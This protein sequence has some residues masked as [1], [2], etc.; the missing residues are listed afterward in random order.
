M[1]IGAALGSLPMPDAR[2]LMPGCPDAS[3]QLVLEIPGIPCSRPR[4]RH[5]AR[6]VGGRAV[7][8]TY[9]PRPKHGGNDP[10]SKAWAKA[11]AWYDAVQVAFWQNRPAD[12]PWEGPIYL[13]ADVFLPRPQKYLR[14][15]DP[16]GP[17]WAHT[18]SS[19]RDN[20]EKS[21]SDALKTA[22]AYGDDRQVV[23]G[24]I[25]KL[26][27]AKGAGPGVVVRMWRITEQPE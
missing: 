1:S 9:H 21:I 15:R 17:I 6:I 4:A 19:D 25:R 8:V 20:L 3:L 13:T 5:A 22:G 18:A 7:S 14:K 10:H 11:N 2:W 26:Y 24:P 23:D 27:H 16:D 12:A